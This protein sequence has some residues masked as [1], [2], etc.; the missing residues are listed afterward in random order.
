MK[1]LLKYHL[2]LG[3]ILQVLAIA[4]SLDEQGFQVYVECN[5]E[6]HSIFKICSYAQAIYPGQ[7]GPPGF[8]FDHILDLQIWPHRYH[9]YRRS[10]KKWWD[11]VTGLYPLLTGLEWRSPFVEPLPS[12]PIDDAKG[13]VVVANAGFSQSP[14]IPP[15][16]VTEFAAKLYP[17]LTPLHL[18][19][20]QVHGPAAYCQVTDLCHIAGLVKNAG[21]VVTINTSVDFFA[22]SLRDQYDHIVNGVEQD[23][24][25]STKQTRHIITA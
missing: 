25:F 19:T 22:D 10:K 3:D 5:A 15:Q 1:I 21:A 18:G 20:H 7:K 23:D 13:Y 17:N 11:F 8:K 2:R 24:F 16:K 12:F 14:K 6:Y 9:D 4:R